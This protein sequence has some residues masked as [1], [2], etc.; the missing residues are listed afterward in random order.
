M[1]FPKLTRPLSLLPP[2]P[3]ED[4]EM[5]YS[6]QGAYVNVEMMSLCLRQVKPDPNG[7][8]YISGCVDFI[9]LAKEYKS[10]TV[11]C[12][13]IEEIVKAYKVMAIDAVD[14]GAKRPHMGVLQADIPKPEK[15]I[16][17]LKLLDV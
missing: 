3:E 12:E 7:K 10:D 17:T 2:H 4:T 5:Q 14:D 1:L 15:H 8:G 13:D 9:R 16:K 11:K 6:S